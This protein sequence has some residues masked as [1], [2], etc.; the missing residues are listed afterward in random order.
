MHINGCHAGEQI[1][2]FLIV[3][4]IQDITIL[5]NNYHVVEVN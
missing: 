2:L 5:E 1:T 4:L 3:N